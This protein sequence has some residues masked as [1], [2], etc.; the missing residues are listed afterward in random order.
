VPVEPEDFRQALSRFASGVTIVTVADDDELHGMTAS[1]FASVS[2]DPP[3]VLVCLDKTS[4]TRAL[5]SELGSFAISVLNAE[6]EEISRAFAHSGPKPFDGLSHKRGENGAPLLD[7]ALAWIECSVVEVIDG[8][9]HDIV[10]GE[11]TACTPSDGEPLIYFDR[12]YRS[13]HDEG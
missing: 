9:D 1:A 4:H 3:R 2:L 12:R 11:V 8:G 7:G 10:L 13:L 6:Q 5:L